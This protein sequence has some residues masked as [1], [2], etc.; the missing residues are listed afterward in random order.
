MSAS[1]EL[2]APEPLSPDHLLADFDSGE[3]SLDEW[4]K[5]RARSNE[6][7]GGSRTFVATVKRR[8]IGYYSLAASAVLHKIAVGNLRRN[9]PDPVPVVLLGR[10]A[11]D[12]HWQRQGIGADLLRDAVLRSVVAA[13]SIGIR[14]LLVHA[15]SEAARAFYEKHGFRPSPIERG[16]L[17]ITIA[18]AT[19]IVL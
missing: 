1:R 13:E 10:L 14:G 11:V 9:M 15:I 2:S 12:R 18:E 4:L 8:A 7:A 3:V 16:T 6:A 19:K 17:M 5:Q